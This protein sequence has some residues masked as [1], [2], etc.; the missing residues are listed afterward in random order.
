MFYLLGCQYE[1]RRFT[2]KEKADTEGCVFFTNPLLRSASTVLAI[3]QVILVSNLLSVDRDAMLDELE[4]F[5]LSFV[6]CF[7]YES[8]VYFDSYEAEK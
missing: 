5:N 6:G 8:S 2:E 4:T 7:D 3:I 1:S